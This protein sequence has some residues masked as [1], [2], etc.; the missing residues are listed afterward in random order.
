MDVSDK[1]LSKSYGKI[2]SRYVSHNLIT[3]VKCV[4]ACYYIPDICVTEDLEV[5]FRLKKNEE[6]KPLQGSAVIS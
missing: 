3:R 6:G 2:I 1:T 4:A 5:I